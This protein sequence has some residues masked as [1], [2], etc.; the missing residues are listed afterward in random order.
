M[1]A[2][3]LIINVS[4]QIELLACVDAEALSSNEIKYMCTISNL[5][6]TVDLS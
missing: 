5:P 1:H 2:C 4:N 6:S 3:M